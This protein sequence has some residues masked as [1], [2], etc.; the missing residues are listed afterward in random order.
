MSGFHF[1]SMNMKFPVILLACIAAV[2]VFAQQ[3]K[4]KTGAAPAAK[5]EITGGLPPDATKLRSEFCW[6]WVLNEV[7]PHI[8]A[9][10]FDSHSICDR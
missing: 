10:A 5:G 1:V 9:E 6:I 4:K 2:S 7:H 8:D 3:P